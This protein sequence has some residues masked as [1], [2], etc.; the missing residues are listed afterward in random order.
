M[1]LGGP[2]GGG[3]DLEG[4]AGG[5]FSDINITPLTDIF[6]VLLVIFMVTTTAIH[7]A[8]DNSG[9]EV[10]LPRAGGAEQPP[11]VP[12]QIAIAVLADGR[13]VVGGKVVS[14]AELESALTDAHGR[15]A[16]T[17]VLVQAD[18]GVVHGRVV[19]VMDLAR[20][21]GLARLAI[22]TRADAR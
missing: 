11:A 12:Q 4:E 17:L 9:F 22:A 14:D 7:E 15:N 8:Q 20:K 19:A 2:N 5:I 21:A 3:D 1:A 18:A 16:D 6:L 13:V 10:N